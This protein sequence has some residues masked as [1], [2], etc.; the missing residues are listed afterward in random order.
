MCFSF[1]HILTRVSC[2][3]IP[4]QVCGW[5]RVAPLSCILVTSN[6]NKKPKYKE[7]DNGSPSPDGST[8]FNANSSASIAAEQYCKSHVGL[9]NLKKFGSVNQQ[10]GAWSE[11]AMAA[12]HA[13]AA[14]W[15]VLNAMQ[16][17][18]AHLL[19]EEKTVE[20]GMHAGTPQLP[21]LSSKYSVAEKKPAKPK[22]YNYRTNNRV[23]PITNFTFLPPIKSPQ[24]ISKA[25]GYFCR[26]KETPEGQ[27]SEKNGFILEKRRGTRVDT[28]ANSDLSTF[29]AALTSKY[30]TYWQN[31]H[32]V[33]IPRRLEYDVSQT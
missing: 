32:N 21:H 18:K 25:S 17:K 22:K 5:A 3:L 7:A 28:A 23:V 2:N 10:M 4:Q 26:G 14:E 19:L 33:S 1:K 31:P 13:D 30:Q 29:S 24:V 6:P 11:S 20:R 8:A 9:D 27:T 12:H 16:R 15:P